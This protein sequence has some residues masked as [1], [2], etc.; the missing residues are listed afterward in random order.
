[1]I[2][3]KCEITQFFVNT[4]RN[5]ILLKK[6]EYN[7]TQ[8]PQ[9]KVVMFIKATLKS[10][11]HALLCLHLLSHHFCTIFHTHKRYS[12]LHKRKEDE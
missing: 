12:S 8:N 1:M 11:D 9:K 2:A 3:I 10:A 6:N 7:K 4:Q 5:K